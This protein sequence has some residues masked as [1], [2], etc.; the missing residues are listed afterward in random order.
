MNSFWNK[1][2]I[3]YNSVGII[4]SRSIAVGYEIADTITKNY[5]VE[6]LKCNTVCPGKFLIVYSS[7]NQTIKDSINNIKHNVEILYTKIISDLHHE[8]INGLKN[9]YSKYEYGAIGIIETYNI[10]NGINILNKILKNNNLKLL[11]LNLG[12]MIGGKSFFI[13]NGD[14]SSIKNAIKEGIN[15]SKE[16]INTSL[17]ASP[18]IELIN[19]L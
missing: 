13:I 18:T 14:I 5:D 8:I 6:L 9:K 10:T 12:L 1:V 17:I 19:K 16:K 3:L 11:K 4:E 7:D 15:E 2:I